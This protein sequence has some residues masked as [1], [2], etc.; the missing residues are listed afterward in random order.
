MSL[1][2]TPKSILVPSV[3][4]YSTNCT[5]LIDIACILGHG[6]SYS[7]ISE[8]NT[9]NAYLIID[10]QDQGTVVPHGV[11]HSSYMCRTTLTD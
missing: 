9:E 4:K 3:M 7:L 5:E 2:K 1:I 6:V 10:Q 11:S 8:L